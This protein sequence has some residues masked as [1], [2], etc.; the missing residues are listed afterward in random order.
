MRVWPVLLDSTPRYLDG[1]RTS[2][3]RMPLP[4]GSVAAR[5]TSVLRQMTALP[6]TVIAPAGVDDLS[7]YR[8]ELAA[9]LVSRCCAPDGFAD[10]LGEMELSDILLLVDPVH[11]TVSADDLAR[12]AA[13]HEG[14]PHVAHHLVVHDRP[15]GGMR[16]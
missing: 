12:L 5:V 11:L 3:L 4:D 14:E 1:T 2:L 10:L 7:A 16:E 6:M 15:S 8:A 9:P 13:T